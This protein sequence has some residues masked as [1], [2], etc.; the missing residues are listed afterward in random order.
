MG[1]AAD[2]GIGSNLIVLS[3][4]DLLNSCISCYGVS[5]KTA[6]G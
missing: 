2:A 3:P 1:T 6:L 4:C 5:V